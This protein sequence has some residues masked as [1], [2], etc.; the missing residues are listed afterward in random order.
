MASKDFMKRR[1]LMRLGVLGA[2]SLANP[3]SLGT[4]AAALSSPDTRQKKVA[5]SL[6]LARFHVPETAARLGAAYMES[7]P[8]EA[9][10]SSIL[11][12]LFS[13]V[14]KLADM[15]AGNGEKE[16]SRTLELA[17][18]AD[19]ERGDVV[20]IDGWIIARTEARLSALALLTR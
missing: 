9:T 13:D 16:L 19:F 11:R 8:A 10:L 4:P 14:P 5:S 18:S 2:A 15:A 6:V 1:Q 3:W 20:S 12:G 17:I 7:T